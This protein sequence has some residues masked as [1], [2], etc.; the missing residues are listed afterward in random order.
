[1]KMPEQT[2][3][4][5]YETA[6]S[7]KSH[8]F[9]G[10]KSLCGEHHF[11]GSYTKSISKPK[12]D[13]CRRQLAKEQEAA[14]EKAVIDGDLSFTFISYRRACTINPWAVWIDRKAGHYYKHYPTLKMA[15][16]ALAAKLTE[17]GVG[18]IPPRVREQNT[19]TKA[20]DK[21]IDFEDAV[22]QAA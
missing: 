14:E 9:K 10:G 13:G 11:A 19:K 1:M 2:V 7:T 17:F 5:W 21:A 15:K 3:I 18:S 4:Y 22:T 8:C 12:C 20:L 16:A 6:R